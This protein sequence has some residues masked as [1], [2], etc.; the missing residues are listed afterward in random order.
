MLVQ[1]PKKILATREILR[2]A[3]RVK[4]VLVKWSLMPKQMETWEDEVTLP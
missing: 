3:R 2:G 4:Q 1:Q